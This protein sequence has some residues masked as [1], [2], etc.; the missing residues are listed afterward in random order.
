MEPSLTARKITHLLASAWTALALASPAAHAQVAPAGALFDLQLAHPA[1][2]LSYEAFGFSFVAT[3]NATTV[4]FSFRNDESFFYFD[5]AVVTRDG[6]S[7]LLQNP[8]FETSLV[9]PPAGW[10]RTLQPRSENGGFVGRIDDPLRDYCNVAHSGARLW[11]DGTVNGYSSLSQTL[12]TTPGEAYHV[13]FWLGAA[14]VPVLPTAPYA[15]VYAYAT[16]G[17]PITAAVPEPQTYLL[18]LAGGALL[19]AGVRRRRRPR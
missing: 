5:D 7:N 14:Y 10:T 13:S 3:L 6:L 15:N 2:L 1:P 8:S 18:M 16:G 17:Q 4:T 9:N 12:L 11:C 19:A